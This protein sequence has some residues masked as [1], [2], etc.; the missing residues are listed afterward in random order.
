MVLRTEDALNSGNRNGSMDGE[1][2]V[3]ARKVARN[4][5]WT[6]LKDA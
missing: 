4:G 3:H 5:F 1:K 6:L 2:K